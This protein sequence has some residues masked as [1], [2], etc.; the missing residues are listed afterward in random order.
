M[1][2]LTIARDALTNDIVLRWAA[3]NRADGYL[4]YRSTDIN[5]LTQT[6]LTPTPIVPNTYTDAGIIGTADR[7]YYVVVAVNNP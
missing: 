5:N 1:T 6:L 2:T 3:T 4:V 7:N